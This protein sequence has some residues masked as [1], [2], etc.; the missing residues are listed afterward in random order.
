MNHSQNT[1][2]MREVRYNSEKDIIELV[3]TYPDTGK[4]VVRPM[5]PPKKNRE[6]VAWSVG[7]GSFQQPHEYATRV[8]RT[9]MVQRRCGDFWFAHGLGRKIDEKIWTCRFREPS[10]Q[11]CIAAIETCKKNLNF[12]G[13]DGKLIPMRLDWM[14]QQME[15]EMKAEQKDKR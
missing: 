1:E 2:K 4:T 13:Y 10:L 9:D 8:S 7:W 12:F 5:I 15:K 11:S 6:R 3:T 14:I